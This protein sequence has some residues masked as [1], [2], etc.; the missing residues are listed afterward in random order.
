MIDDFISNGFEH[1]YLP[2]HPFNKKVKDAL[3]CIRLIKAT[4]K[5]YDV[6]IVHSHHRLAEFYALMSSRVNRIPTISTAHAL[7][8]G[9]KNLSFRSDKLI[10]VSNIVK[11]ML[12]SDFKVQ[13][14]KT[15]VIRNIPRKFYEPPV[16][17][18]EKFKEK[19]GIKEEGFVVAGIGRLHHEKGFDVFLS[20]MKA[21]SDLK[22]VKAIL[23]GKGA[24]KTL[25]Q[26]Y[27][28]ENNINI[29]FVDE[30]NDVEL[31]YKSADVIVVPSRQESAGLVA[32][33]AGYFQKPV[34]ASSVGGLNETIKDD[35]TGL[36]VMPE[37][38]GAL[39]QAIRRLYNDRQLCQILGKQLS[40]YV[41]KEYAAD[42]ISEQVQLVYEQLMHGNGR[43]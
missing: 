31:I 35:I 23:A 12:V 38:P 33:E 39:A 6:D 15:S 43:S 2:I 16:A 10:A 22:Q 41:E 42:K 9:K 19:A 27:S 11:E 36:S 25:L 28:V 29:F 13:E 40:D 1:V 18:V 24:E 7:I 32:I 37:N 34:I 26:K 3:H 30:I 5:K 8:A 17:D 21:L 4:V 14:R 20:A